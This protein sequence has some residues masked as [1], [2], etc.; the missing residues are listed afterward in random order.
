MVQGS[1]DTLRTNDVDESAAADDPWGLLLLNCFCRR[2]SAV[3]AQLIVYNCLPDPHNNWH[4]DV[5][6]IANLRT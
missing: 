1:H 3:Y 6:H 2:R 4:L 5:I